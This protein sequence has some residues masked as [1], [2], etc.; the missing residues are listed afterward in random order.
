M[1]ADAAPGALTEEIART[2]EAVPGVA[3]LRPGL[4]GRLRSTLPR[5]QEGRD[6]TP[7]AGVRLSRTGSAGRWHVEIHLVALRGARALDVARA[8][9]RSVE[10]Y[11]LSVLSAEAAPTAAPAHVT[12]TVT[13][14][15]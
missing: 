1:T 14:R 15:V 12:V 9:R 13:G 11:L 8:A 10:A 3:F 2:V 4:A 6:R 7:T 5:P